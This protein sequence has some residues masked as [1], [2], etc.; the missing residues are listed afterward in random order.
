MAIARLDESSSFRRYGVKT[1]ASLHPSHA[2]RG[3]LPF[4]WPRAAMVFPLVPPLSSVLIKIC[5]HTFFSFVCCERM[6]NCFRICATLGAIRGRDPSKA[7]EGSR[8]ARRF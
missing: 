8:G 1:F 6:G 2:E 4:T 7:W 5:H 3:P